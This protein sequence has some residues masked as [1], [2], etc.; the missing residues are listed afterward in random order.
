MKTYLKKTFF[1]EQ[2]RKNGIVVS[3]GC[4]FVRKY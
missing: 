4:D 2:S 1:E 3:N